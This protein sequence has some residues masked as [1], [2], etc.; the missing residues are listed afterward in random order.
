MR[1]LLVLVLLGLILASSVAVV[2]G[3]W[4]AHALAA[5]PSDRS[6][7]VG[8]APMALGATKEAAAYRAG[9]GPTALPRPGSGLAA[10][11]CLGAAPECLPLPPPGPRALG[12]GAGAGAV[13]EV[14]ATLAH[15]PVGA[16]PSA[17]LVDASS[18]LTYI[19]NEWSDN[20]T[21]ISDGAVVASIAVGTAPVAL[22][23]GGTGGPVYV[24]ASGSDNVTVISEKSREAVFAVG[25]V[26][27][28][29]AFVPASGLLYVANS[30]AGTVTVVNGTERVA[31]V[32]VGGDPTYLAV[33]PVRGWVYAVEPIAGVVKVL[34][35]TRI[36]ATISGFNDPT[37]ALYDPLN[38]YVYVTDSGNFQLTILNGSAALAHLSTADVGAL[39]LGPAGTVYAAGPG[40]DQVAVINGTALEGRVNLTGPAG[41]LTY[42]A[43]NGYVY[44]TLVGDGNPPGALEAIEGLRSVGST[45]VPFTPEM[46]AYDSAGA[47]LVV[48]G[49]VP[50]Q[51]SAGSVAVLSTMLGITSV[52][53]APVGTP[54]GS[55]DAGTTETITTTLWAVGNGTDHA[56]LAMDP[57][58][59]LTCPSAPTVNNSSFASVG[60]EVRCVPETPGLYTVG[61]NVTDEQGSRVEARGVLRVFPVPATSVPVAEVGG[62]TDRP[63][64]YVN[65]SVTFEAGTTG[66]TGRFAPLLWSGV[67]PGRCVEATATTLQCTLTGSGRFEI[68]A[69]TVDSNG[70]VALSP[71]LA[72]EVFLPPYVDGAPAATRPA[73]D[74]GETVGFIDS[75]TVGTGGT[76]LYAWNG[77]PGGACSSLLS[78]QIACAFVAPG[79]Y[80]LSVRV[81]DANGRSVT[82]PSLAFTV[83]PLPSIPAP[84]RAKRSSVDVGQPFQLGLDVAGGY[85][86]VNVTWF[87]LPSVCGGNATDSPVCLA[88]SPGVLS[89]AAQATDANGGLSP[90]SL[91]LRLTVYPDPSVTTPNLSATIVPAG[92]SVFLGT[93]VSGGDGHVQLA[94][95]GLPTGCAVSGDSG[96]CVP[97]I[98]GTYIL[99]VTAQDSNGFRVRSPA[100]VLIV[101][102]PA[103]VAAPI[104]AGPFLPDGP[105]PYV[106]LAAVVGAGLVIWG[107]RR[108]SR[109]GPPAYEVE[110]D[111]PVEATAPSSPS[112]RS[113]ST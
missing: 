83:Y 111:A 5:A 89:V 41:S 33:D 22:V 10:P 16:S 94:W 49:T 58:G 68:R 8:E 7:V 3:P 50:G 59:G 106:L 43:A 24:I 79:T 15:F 20:V 85:G 42:D 23:S 18:G 61:F 9:S 103:A 104:G 63:F 107:V 66:G 95:Q 39:A 90:P 13:A 73:V 91:P 12:T 17:I 55:A 11:G 87:G 40:T 28:A 6:P 102:A 74:V 92:G 14:G 56:T 93:D 99:S 27:T 29:A 72:F 4:A 77:V 70:V 31:T 44:A 51:A 64:A 78:A 65:G 75:G 108:W 84:P 76:P 38:G 57:A 32:R 45:S 2:P 112:G 52:E 48:V 1:R 86:P 97:T 62:G 30:N 96:P 105:I 110:W 69:S 19:A 34:N 54:A 67:P 36:Q 109:P 21:V 113:G 98:P 71:P 82:G 88:T 53:W 25:S 81:T 101:V 47:L 80:D 26:P 60:L 37:G 35:G 46:A 100:T